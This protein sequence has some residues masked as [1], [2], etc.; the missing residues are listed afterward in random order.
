L[1]CIKISEEFYWA[2]LDDLSLN[3]DVNIGPVVDVSKQ[4][5]EN[6]WAQDRGSSTKMKGTA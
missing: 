6:I 5:S 2:T 4:I 1:L 3:P